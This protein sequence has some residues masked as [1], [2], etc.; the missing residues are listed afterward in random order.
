MDVTESQFQL[1]YLVDGLDKDHADRVSAGQGHSSGEYILSCSRLVLK[2]V[3]VPR[4][5]PGI[6]LLHH[7]PDPQPD[8]NLNR[9]GCAQAPITRRGQRRPQVFATARGG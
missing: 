7:N 1:N 5:D 4:G 3:V 2:N 8:P 9:I 6:L